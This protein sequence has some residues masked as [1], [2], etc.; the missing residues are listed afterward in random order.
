MTISVNRSITGQWGNDDDT[1]SEQTIR[2]KHKT[3]ISIDTNTVFF[4]CFEF[5]SRSNGADQGVKLKG[6]P[7]VD[8]DDH[9]GQ[10][11]NEWS[12][13]S[14]SYDVIRVCVILNDRI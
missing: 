9:F 3:P 10:L 5:I 13:S 11:A 6:L 2:G 12:Y 4:H 8:F 14:A 1:Y 7:A